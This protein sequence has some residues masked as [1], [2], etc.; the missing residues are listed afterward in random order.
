MDAVDLQSLLTAIYGDL[1]ETE[2]NEWSAERDAE[3]SLQDIETPDGINLRFYTNVSFK[4]GDGNA[5]SKYFTVKINECG[6]S[7]TLC[8]DVVPKYFP[9][10]MQGDLYLKDPFYVA[11]TDYRLMQSNLCSTYFGY[12]DGA[13]DATTSN[14]GNINQESNHN[15]FTE[16]F[17]KYSWSSYPRALPNKVY[18]SLIIDGGHLSDLNGVPHIIGNEGH[19]NCLW[20]KNYDSKIID[21]RKFKFGS[22]ILEDCCF[23][24]LVG[25][26]E[27]MDFLIIK[28]GR[29]F[30]Q[31]RLKYRHHFDIQFPEIVR[32]KFSIQSQG[33]AVGRKPTYNIGD[34][35]VYGAVSLRDVYIDGNL[36]LENHDGDLWTDPSAYLEL[37]NVNTIK[38]ETYTGNL[39]VIVDKTLRGIRIENSDIPEFNTPTS[40]A[41]TIICK[42]LKKAN[43]PEA[44]PRISGNTMIF[45]NCDTSV[46]RTLCNNSQS[47]SNVK[48]LGILGEFESNTA[49]DLTPFT[50][51]SALLIDGRQ[52]DA[53]QLDNKPLLLKLPYIEP[54]DE[55]YEK[56]LPHTSNLFFPDLFQL[57]M[58]TNEIQIWVAEYETNFTECGIIKNANA[59]NTK[60]YAVVFANLLPYTLSCNWESIKD[61][62]YDFVKVKIHNPFE[63]FAKF[64]DK[65]PHS[66]YGVLF[67]EFALTGQYKKLFEGRLTVKQTPHDEACMDFFSNF[68]DYLDLMN[69]IGK[70]I[71][72]VAP[73]VEGI[74][75]PETI[76][77]FTDETPSDYISGYDFTDRFFSNYCFAH[78]NT[79]TNKRADENYLKSVFRPIFDV[80]AREIMTQMMTGGF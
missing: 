53:N 42:N 22:L 80:Q 6:L 26:P 61:V 19:R 59:A 2:T 39:T 37:D 29:K 33:F 10:I 49:L 54:I 56:Y 7:V 36:Y 40:H 69:Q 34:M 77:H 48:I 44:E 17:E 38:G 51:L 28:E 41:S 66:L 55:Q 64:G 24:K 71:T 21:L 31:G 67:E 16:A 74:I 13:Y 12:I 20:L 65:F 5:L 72:N 1:K 63:F 18:G 76:Q 70:P 57:T 45:D 58:N 8:R 27:V 79:I 60:Q 23:Q 14:A 73:L 35:I 15:I 11:S 3:F 62:Q 32:N 68:A 47:K 9:K 50:G 43:L 52:R 46:L 25:L 78:Y 30:E 75:T 4:S